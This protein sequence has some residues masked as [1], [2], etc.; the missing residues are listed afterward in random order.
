M[1]TTR[2]KFDPEDPGMVYRAYQDSR[3]EQV[4]ADYLS[5]L[6]ERRGREQ[7]HGALFE[8]G[9][10]EQPELLY[11][12]YQA[13][14]DER[15][16]RGIASV[17]DEVRERCESVPESRPVQA[18]QG[19][20][21]GYLQRFKALFGSRNSWIML[22]SLGV[23]ALVAVMILPAM[24]GTGTFDPTGILAHPPSSNVLANAEYLSTRLDESERASLGFAGDLNDRSSAFHAG[25]TT[26]DLVIA[27]TARQKDR[28]L[29]M[30]KQFSHL[31]GDNVGEDFTEILQRDMDAVSKTGFDDGYSPAELLEAAQKVYA[32]GVLDNAFMSG[33]WVESLL[34]E[35][36]LAVHTGDVA[37]LNQ[38][39][40][41][42][43]AG[44]NLEKLSERSRVASRLVEQL[45]S[46]AGSDT[47]DDDSA[48]LVRDAARRLKY[49]Y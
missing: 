17:M 27:T 16:E 9:A 18:G 37:A 30:L 6:A 4:P 14:R 43:S 33:Q 42:D 49:V 31:V 29:S 15:I 1:N 45:A 19:F 26:V 24:L 10:E 2:D 3:Q 11:R 38:M 12:Q 28:T 25:A 34:L 46:I 22:P 21:T 13:T 44:E 23:A 48:R 36:A 8:A 5:L 40:K 39:L 41:N 20:V 47:V 32:G 35:A 7:A